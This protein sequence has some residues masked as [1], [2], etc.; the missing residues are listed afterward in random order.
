MEQI[1]VH[2][3]ASIEEAQLGTIAAANIT[4]AFYE[5][6][7]GSSPG[8]DNR[9][10]AAVELAIGEAS[11][12]A[13]K[14]CSAMGRNCSKISIYF[15]FEGKTLEVM[16]KDHNGVFDFS[17]VAAPDFDA[18]PEQGYGIF[19]MKNMMDEVTYQHVDGW[20]IITMKKKISTEE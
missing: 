5:V 4:K 11:T 8:N 12:N 9:F 18:M 10:I 6:V 1:E 13:A 3:Q 7:T 15:R 17:G 14:Y 19:I 2:F 20:N 16:I